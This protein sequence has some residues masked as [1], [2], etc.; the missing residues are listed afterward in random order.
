MKNQNISSESSGSSQQSRREFIRKAIYASPVLLTLPAIPSFAQTG[1]G[2]V[3]GGGGPVGGDECAPTEPVGGGLTEM[4]HFG[5]APASLSNSTDIL[6][7]QSEIAG[8]LARGSRFGPCI[9]FFCG[10][11]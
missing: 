11:S 9:A 8:E 1:S 3:G 7:E 2:P 6:V 10:A 5:P 4:C